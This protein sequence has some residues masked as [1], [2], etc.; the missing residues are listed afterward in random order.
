[1][2][3]R[4]VL[5][6]TLD[7]LASNKYISASAAQGT[8]EATSAKIALSFDIRPD[9]SDYESHAHGAVAD[10]IINWLNGITS[11]ENDYLLKCKTALG[12]ETVHFGYLCSLVPAYRR[13]LSNVTGLDL[14]TRPNAFA[15]DPGTTIE[16]NV[17]VINIQK[18]EEYSKL[19]MVDADGHLITFCENSDLKKKMLTG[20]VV[21]DKVYVSSKVS[22]NKFSTPFETTLYKPTIKKIS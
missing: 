10:D 13:H 20:L 1:M 6:R 14:V 7:Y 3:S 12:A 18:F 2:D 22:K 8:G 11:T 17:T 4:S 16:L 21:G 15:G 9:I 19:S 5:I